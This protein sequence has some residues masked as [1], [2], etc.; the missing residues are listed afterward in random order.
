M[1]NQIKEV[2][3]FNSFVIT[4]DGKDD[5]EIRNRIETVKDA[6]QKRSKELGDRKLCCTLISNLLFGS[7]S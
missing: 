7:E 5:T 4:D 1:D 3:K 6:F 2:E